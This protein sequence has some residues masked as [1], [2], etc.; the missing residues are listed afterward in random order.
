MTTATP[1]SRLQA[2]LSALSLL[3]ASL[4]IA[5]AIPQPAVAG[6]GAGSHYMPGTMGDFAMALIGPQGFYLRNDVLYFQGN[7]N[8][9]T[10]GDR[11]YSSA[12]QDI[13]VDTV[14]GIYLAK[15]GVL[16]G[17][18]GF[19]VS[20]PIVL[21]A[22]VAGQLVE[23]FEGEA[24]GSR[25]GIS[26]PSLTAFNNWSSG[27]HHV[28]TGLT[29]FLPLGAYDED[30]IVNLGRN[31]WSFDPLV[32]YTW[33][34]P[35]R[36]HEVS[37]TTGFM[38]NTDN[39]ATDYSSGTEW[40]L[41]FMAAQHFSPRLAL[42]L[43]GSVLQGVTDDESPLLD[44][45]NAILPAIGLEPVDGFKAR[46]FGLGPAAVVTPKIS[47]KDVNFIAKYL[48]DVTHENRFNSDYLMVSAAFKF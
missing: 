47:G 8:A 25:S 46:Y 31:Y 10:L 16:G 32:T 15:S 14:K 41:D 28:S 35:K 21:N 37:L 22:K 42:G 13:W 2:A 48:F 33:L 43:E 26:D 1:R 30:R 3:A 20:L 18:L 34:H 39:D 36:G 19:V 24:S 44:Q 23:P 5:F 29:V 17:R 38:F 40:H 7:I 11:I 6:E 9:V 4:L 12:S 27:N 45:A